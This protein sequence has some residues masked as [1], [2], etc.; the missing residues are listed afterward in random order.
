L[1]AL[2]AVVYGRDLADTTATD[3]RRWLS[4][5]ADNLPALGPGVIAWWRLPHCA[6]KWPLRIVAGLATGL[7]A[8]FWASVVTG[9]IVPDVWP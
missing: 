7:A 5:F 4:F 1:D 6:P 8:G 9:L 3:A 2:V